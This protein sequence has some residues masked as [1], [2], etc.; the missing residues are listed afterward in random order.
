MG[1]LLV[2][3]FVVLISFNFSYAEGILLGVAEEPSDWTPSPLISKTEPRVRILF[4]KE[5]LLKSIIIVRLRK[6][7]FFQS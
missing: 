5:K 1:K 6:K 2:S 3:I 4:H 7:M